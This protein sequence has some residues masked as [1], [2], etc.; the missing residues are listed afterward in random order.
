MT[1]D[2]PQLYSELDLPADCTLD[3][4]KRAY[5]R[6]IAQLH[7]DRTG[8][9]GSPDDAQAALSELIATYVAVNT[10][11]RRYGRM[12]G[13]TPRAVASHPLLSARPASRPSLPSVVPSGDDNERPAGS[14]IWLAVLFL[15]LLVLLASW[16]WLTLST[17]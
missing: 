9:D 16:D 8:T 5:R 11:H 2:F 17:Q 13:T 3:D 4:F 1:P 10:F 15:A 14:S 12:P 7:P 6:R